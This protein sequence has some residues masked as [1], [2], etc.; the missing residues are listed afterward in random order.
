MQKDSKMIKCTSRNGSVWSTVW[1]SMKRYTSNFD[2]F[3]GIE[4]KMRKEEM[5][6]QF[7]KEAKQGW[8]FA[9]RI[10]DEKAGSGDRKH[11]SGGLFKAINS[12]PGAVIG[13]KWCSKVSPR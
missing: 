3:F 1:E 10:T 2:I 9:A 4:H 7:N 12:N 11:T 8:R 13:K 6:E 5:E